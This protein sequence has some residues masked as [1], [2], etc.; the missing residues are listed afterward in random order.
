MGDWYEFEIRVI[1]GKEVSGFCY[2]NE[3]T[4]WQEVFVE[5]TESQKRWAEEWTHNVNEMMEAQKEA[6]KSWLS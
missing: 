2:Q 5:F 3:A 4:G 6:I 1:D